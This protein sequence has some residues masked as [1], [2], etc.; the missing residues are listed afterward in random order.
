VDKN[1]QDL[2]AKVIDEAQAELD[3][4]T[5]AQSEARARVASLRQALPDAGQNPA[6]AVE[7]VASPTPLLAWIST[8]GN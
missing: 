2:F 8:E 4:L 3:R 5:R 6:L 1:Q 7:V